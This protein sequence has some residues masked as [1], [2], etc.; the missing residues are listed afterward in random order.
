MSKAQLE[1]IVE[2]LS[3][4]FL[5]W[6]PGIDDQRRGWDDFF[7]ETPSIEAS[8]E[9]VDAGGVAAEW[10]RAAEAEDSRVILFLHGGGYVSGSIRS[11]RDLCARLSRAA[12]GRVLA[13]GY[14]LA[15][16]HPHPAALEDAMAAYRWLL[17]EGIASE[18]IAIA[19][20]SAGGG[21]ALA[22][23]VALRD[24]GDP[25]PACAV[26]ICPWIDLERRGGSIESKAADDPLVREE[27]L[28]G[29]AALYVPDESRRNDPLVSPIYAN[30]QGLPPL[31]VHVGSR[32]VLLEDAIRLDAKAKSAGV[33]CRIEVWEGQTHVWHVFAARLEE[34]EEAIGALGKFIRDRIS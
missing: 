28:Q 30:L 3:R 25:V 21:L 18:C 19:G 5:E 10:I 12:R 26:L 14:R 2:E 1:A 13:L 11:H 7:P 6:G 33:D 23:L 27:A 29:M 20:D 9:P 4:A 32:E 15:P 34:G 8:L 24:S 22:A 16:E 31:L 17:G